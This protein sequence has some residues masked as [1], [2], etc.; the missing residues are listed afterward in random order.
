MRTLLWTIPC[1]AVLCIP[2]TSRPVAAAPRLSLSEIISGMEGFE[3]TFLEQRSWRVDVT[4]KREYHNLSTPATSPH[5][6]GKYVNARMGELLYLRRILQVDPPETSW[7]IWKDDICTYRAG[8]V[9]EIRAE[10]HPHAYQQF[11]YT[12]AL[13]L[14]TYR[15]YRFLT[16]QYKDAWGAE[17]P[18]EAFWMALPRGIIAHKQSFQLRPET[19]SVDGAPCYVLERPGKDIIFVDADHGFICRRRIYYQA[20]GVVLFEQR[21]RQLLEYAPGLWL[22]RLQVRKYYH[23]DD[24][25][26]ALRGKLRLVETNTVSQLALGTLTEDFFTVPVP[27]RAVV[28]D[29]IR[30]LHYTK[31]PEDVREQD[32]LDESINLARVHSPIEAR[33]RRWIPWVLVNAIVLSSLLLLHQIRKRRNR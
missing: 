12:D 33:R 6:V 7:C 23:A 15:G 25:P 29:R 28:V 2:P 9:V 17:T 32:I 24:S 4:Q 30:G 1:A 26:G 14:D 27:E 19:E 20:A 3:R 22:P 8:G 11:F 10:L 5:P 18:S 16:Q 13:F 31:Y 21:N